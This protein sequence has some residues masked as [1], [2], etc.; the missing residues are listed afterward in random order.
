MG[1]G[2]FVQ[3]S[4]RCTTC[5]AAFDPPALTFSAFVSVADDHWNP[6]TMADQM[7]DDR[8]ETES[9]STNDSERERA[10][11]LHP[12]I[13]HPN[14]APAPG[15]FGTPTVCFRFAHARQIDCI[16]Q[17]LN[18]QAYLPPAL[19][20]PRR[21]FPFWFGGRRGGTH[22]DLQKLEVGWVCTGPTHQMPH[23]CSRKSDTGA[24]AA[25]VC[26]QYMDA[27]LLASVHRSH[28]T[29]CMNPRY[30]VPAAHV[31]YAYLPPPRV[32]PP[33]PPGGEPSLGP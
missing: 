4:S 25:G 2:C 7:S 18:D 16:P 32:H 24:S 10:V 11:S 27:C 30:C 15:P 12:Y 1:Q 28:I 17:L 5:K 3:I 31:L 13:S 26:E 6:N 20:S 29:V 22:V 23:E 19:H 8:S 21:P 9:Q 33:P 14:S